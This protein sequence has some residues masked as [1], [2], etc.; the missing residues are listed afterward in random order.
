MPP[1][2][3]RFTSV[4]N[5][6]SLKI[7]CIGIDQYLGTAVTNL[8]RSIWFRGKEQATVTRGRGFNHSTNNCVPELV[9]IGVYIKASVLPR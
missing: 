7:G 1:I 9:C 5:V 4:I 8:R 3:I 2:V 6:T